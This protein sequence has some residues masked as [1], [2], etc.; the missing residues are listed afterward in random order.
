[1]RLVVAINDRCPISYCARRPIVPSI[2]TASDTW[3]DQS[4]PHATDR[5]N[6]RGILHVTDRTSTRG[7]MAPDYRSYD[8]SGG[9]AT[10]D[11]TINRS[12][13][14]VGSLGGNNLHGH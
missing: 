7:I 4:L 6:N 3:Y 9:G 11:R 14:F 8:Q 2:V 10:I 12:I 13:D 5:T 1:M